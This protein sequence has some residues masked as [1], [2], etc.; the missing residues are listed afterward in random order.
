MSRQTL[1]Q[2]GAT[3]L[4]AAV[5]ATLACIQWLD[6]PVARFFLAASGHVSG[7]AQ[8]VGSDE[9]VAGEC[10]LMLLLALTR[11]LHGSL[12]V[13]GKVIFIACC[14][15]LCAFAANDYVLKFI[16]GRIGVYTFLGDPSLPQF[17]FFQGSSDSVFPS[18]HM[19]MAAAFAGV[20]VRLYPRS[21]P[22]FA[23]LLALGAFLLLIGDWHFL[24]DIIAGLFIGG[25]LGV[26]AGE[27]WY[28]HA[29]R[30]RL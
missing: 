21:W 24:G 3:A 26:L 22:L 25:L 6:V 1:L 7:L 29:R 16:F 5:M 10:L 12:P 20:L 14:T 18:G 4:A 27:L 17:Q 13:V 28:Q 8:I 11:I 2:W 15:S 19:V 23:G 9:M 30:A